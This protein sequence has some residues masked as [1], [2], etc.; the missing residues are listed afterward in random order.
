M[1][2]KYFYN[3]IYINIYNYGKRIHCDIFKFNEEGLI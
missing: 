1:G 2:K 3:Y